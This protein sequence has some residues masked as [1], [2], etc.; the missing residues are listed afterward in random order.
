[1][2]MAYWLKLNVDKVFSRLVHCNLHELSIIKR[3][4]ATVR[5]VNPDATVRIVNPDATV[6]IVNPDATV[7]L[8]IRITG[9]HKIELVIE[10]AL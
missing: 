5:I 6:R 1:M 9:R 10:I 8:S 4:D 3:P 7:G 2:N